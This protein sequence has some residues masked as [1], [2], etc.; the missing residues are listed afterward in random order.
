M[1]IKALSCCIALLLLAGSAFAQWNLEYQQE[2]QIDFSAVDF[3]TSMVGYMVGTGGAIYKTTDGGD[4]WV[5]QTSPTTLT[6]YDVFFKSAT[7][8]WAVGDNGLIAV[9][10]DGTNWALHDS[11]G[12]MTTQDINTVFFVGSSGWL[13]TDAS[14]LYLTTNNGVDWTVPTT[15]AATDDVNEISFSD[16][17]NG[18]AAIDGAGIMYTTDGGDNW[19]L[20]AVNLGPY[21]YTRTDI[22]AIRAVDGTYGIAS[23]WGSY[24]GLQ[25]TIIL[26]TS[27]GGATWATPDPTYPWAT[28]A[29][30]YGIAT[31]DDGHAI[32]TGGYSNC[33]A[34]VL[35]ADANYTTWG[36]SEAF[37]GDNVMDIAAV[38]G[39]NR[40]VAVGDGGCVALSTDK[41]QTW[42][43]TY[44]PSNGFNGIYAFT[45]VGKDMIIGVGDGGMMFKGDLTTDPV[46]WDI[47]C[48]APEQFAPTL[49]DVEYINGVL[50]VSGSN[51]YL[52]KS[53][54]LG[55]TWTQLEY[56][57]DLNHGIYSM[58][59]FDEQ[60]GVLC[61][62]SGATSNDDAIWTTSD[63]GETL[64]LVWNNVR[65]VQLN[66][67]AF[68]P[69]S[70]LIGVV[71]GDDNYLLYTSDGGATWTPGTEDIADGADDIEE[72]HMT[73][74]LVGWAV[75]DDGT[76]CKTTDA[77]ANWTMLTPWTGI[78]L[79]DVY[80]SYPNFGWIVGYDAYALYTDDGGATWNDISEPTLGVND[81]NAVYFHSLGG[82]LW[83]GVDYAIMMSRS[84]YATGDDTP[85]NLQFRLGQNFPNPFNP[86][87]T[88]KFSLARDGHVTLNVYD[89]SGHLVA[90]VLDREMP[91]GDHEIGFKAD[92]LASGVYFYRLTA[93][94]MTTT[95]K[96]ILLR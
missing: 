41:G 43:F 81:I 24:V 92:G 25:P 23:G 18:Y 49:H 94:E 83:I 74:A 48:V 79:M 93:G 77:G 70:A 86:S 36:P 39:T 20:A 45:H 27:D 85:I 28:Y 61:G 59:W 60:N 62:E 5:E 57:A 3:P 50:Y 90:A 15:N 9:T 52:C 66:S 16:A 91:S 88:I 21:P 68:A 95:K 82:K 26:V 29:Y 73:S 42:D 71:G 69:G 35:H 56:Y 76:V 96:M 53:T 67:V 75:G 34:P 58:V 19:A 4:T 30:G 37:F 54:D 8:G 33:A 12:V 44:M 17:L 46:T 31:F 38:P 72:V 11:S 40:V 65:G 2:L 6:F 78:D 32:I 63:G 22:E 10:T 55:D 89:V 51:G 64:N 84:D 1:K 80:F 14:G 87:T 47:S 7:E 13:G